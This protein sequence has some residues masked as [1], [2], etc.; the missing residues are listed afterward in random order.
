MT[1]V[2]MAFG[3]G[4]PRSSNRRLRLLVRLVFSGNHHAADR[5]G[6]SDVTR[7]LLG[8]QR[9]RCGR[10]GPNPNTADAASSLTGLTLTSDNAVRDRRSFPSS[11]GCRSPKRLSCA[12]NTGRRRPRVRF[13]YIG[14]Y[15]APGP[16]LSNGPIVASF[17]GLNQT[18]NLVTFG[19]K[20]LKSSL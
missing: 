10:G 1:A 4:F 15:W 6:F 12:E 7:R 16:Q 2:K 9:R 5:G 11:L 14:D 17:S 19:P 8:A 3:W 20:M 13:D 18:Q